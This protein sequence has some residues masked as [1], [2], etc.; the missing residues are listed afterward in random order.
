MIMNNDVVYFVTGLELSSY[1]Y[2]ELSLKTRTFG[3][4]F[5][6]EDAKRLVLR[7]AADIAEGGTFNWA[8]IEGVKSQLYV[9]Y[10]ISQNFFEYRGDGDIDGDFFNVYEER[11]HLPKSIIDFC[12]KEH[13]YTDYFTS[14]G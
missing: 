12:E 8:V 13:I 5:S 11:N 10:A 14:I 6:Y 9:H 1:G 2:E 7:N 4:F 3:W